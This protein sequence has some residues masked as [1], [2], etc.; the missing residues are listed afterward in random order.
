[1]SFLSFYF[2]SIW[3]LYFSWFL[4]DNMCLDWLLISPNNS[5]L[6]FGCLILTSSVFMDVLGLVCLLLFFFQFV[7]TFYYMC[8]SFKLS[9]SGQFHYPILFKSVFYLNLLS[10]KHRSSG[11]NGCSTHLTHYNLYRGHSGHFPVCVCVC[12]HLSHPLLSNIRHYYIFHNT[13]FMFKS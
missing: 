8:S 10:V 3:S 5:F 7:Q 11:F 13:M 12:L 1:M 4:I 2:Q 9:L 6:L